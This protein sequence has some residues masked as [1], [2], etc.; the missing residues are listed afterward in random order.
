MPAT[1]QLLQTH[2]YVVRRRH[3]YVQSYEYSGHTFVDP[4]QPQPPPVAVGTRTKP[5]SP[6]EPSIRADGLSLVIP[7]AEAGWPYPD[8]RFT[9]YPDDDCLSSLYSLTLSQEVTRTRRRRSCS[10]PHLSWLSLCSRCAFSF[11]SLTFSVSTSAVSV[12]VVCLSVLSSL[13][14]A[15]S[16]C[17]AARAALP[18]R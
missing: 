4:P 1:C 11:E 3:K 2:T 9:T 8:G 10:W 18:E 12:S 6:P 17:A 7:I 15:S 14:Q 5:L 16:A 13:W